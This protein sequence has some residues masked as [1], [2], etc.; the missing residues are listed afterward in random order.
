MGER[1]PAAY[2]HRSGEPRERQGG[3]SGFVFTP[4]G[5]Y[6]ATASFDSTA[7]VWETAT[8][9]PAG[10]TADQVFPDARIPTAL[11]AMAK[12]SSPVMAA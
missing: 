5:R 2:R 12:R 4:D 3:G 7:R 6:F 11:P 1:E 10:P 9:R 8:G